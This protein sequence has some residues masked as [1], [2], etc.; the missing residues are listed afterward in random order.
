MNDI[1]GSHPAQ[2]MSEDADAAKA[3]DPRRHRD[4][5]LPLEIVRR[6]RRALLRR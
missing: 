6:H 3:P 1:T 4:E 5:R 2:A